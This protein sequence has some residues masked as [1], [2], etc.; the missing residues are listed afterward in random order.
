[1]YSLLER[2]RRRVMDPDAQVERQSTCEA[3]M[4]SKD[5]S[6]KTS[7]LIFCFISAS[8]KKKTNSYAILL[9]LDRLEST[10]RALL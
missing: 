10:C 5:F 6:G 4:E 3:F 2:K 7:L 9:I 1:M 8:V